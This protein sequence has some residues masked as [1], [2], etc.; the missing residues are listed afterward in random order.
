M[1]ACAGQSRQSQTA[2]TGAAHAAAHLPCS[3]ASMTAEWKTNPARSAASPAVEA[4]CE[5]L[6]GAK[7]AVTDSRYKSRSRNSDISLCSGGL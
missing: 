3:G 7:P 2:V 1:S 5:R 4:L 6:R